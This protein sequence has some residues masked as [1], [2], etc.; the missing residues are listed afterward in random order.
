MF[1]CHFEITHFP[2]LVVIKNRFVLS[3]IKVIIFIDTEFILYASSAFIL[4]W[5]SRLLHNLFGTF[6]FKPNIFVCSFH[7][8]TLKMLS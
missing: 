1:P 5:F 8:E 2:N 7:S 4:F 3:F 6:F